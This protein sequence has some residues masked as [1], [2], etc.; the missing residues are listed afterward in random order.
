MAAN[1]KVIRKTSRAGDVHE[2]MTL[3]NRLVLLNLNYNL[4]DPTLAA[5]TTTTKVKTTAGGTYVVDGVLKGKGATD[6]LWDMS[7]VASVVTSATQYNIYLLCL[8]AAGTASVVAG[9][10][11]SALADVVLPTVPDGKTIIGF[12]TASLVAG[13]FTPGTTAVNAAGVTLTPGVPAAY[14]PLLATSGGVQL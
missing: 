2:L 13:G 9:T 12:L 5:A 6:N 14:T 4:V 11:A 8:D 1:Q 7:T 10:P 3:V